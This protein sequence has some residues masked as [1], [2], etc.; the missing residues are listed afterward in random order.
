MSIIPL[1]S[2]Q[3]RLIIIGFASGPTLSIKRLIG[4]FTA[5]MAHQPIVLF[6]VSAVILV[7]EEERFIHD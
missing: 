4:V 7:S 2:H 1:I 6:E 5:V 3:V